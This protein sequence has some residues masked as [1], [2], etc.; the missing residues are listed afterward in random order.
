MVDSEIGVIP[1]RASLEVALP[2]FSGPLD[3]LLHLIQRQRI[4]IYDIPI[5]LICD[6]YHGFLRQMEQLDLEVAAEFLWMAS[7]LLELKS[8]LLLP[9]RDDSGP[10][11][12]QELVERLLEYRRYKELAAVFHEW[13]VVR[14]CLWEPALRVEVETGDQELDIDEVDLRVLATTYLEVMRRFAADHP[15]PLEVEPLR[16]RVED[17]MGELYRRVT[18]EGLVPLLRHLHT[19]SDVDEVVVFVVAAL[20]LVRLGGI[21][22]EQSRPFAEIYLRPGRTPLDLDRLLQPEASRAT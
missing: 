7:W 8:K 14:R 1:E 18:S 11:P 19:R 10:D 22:A 4:S 5:A 2:V 3:L 20:E 9:R 21:C 12:R 15:P 13:E 16:H 6:Q 17:T